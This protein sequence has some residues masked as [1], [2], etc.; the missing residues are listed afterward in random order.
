MGLTVKEILDTAL[1]MVTDNGG[2]LRAKSVFWLHEVMRDV[3]NQPRQWE[4]L[5]TVSAVLV[6]SSNQVTLPVDCGEVFNFTVDDGQGREYFF[7]PQEALLS[8]AESFDEDQLSGVAPTGYTLTATTLIF[9]PA[10]SGTCTINYEPKL[11]AV[12]YTDTDLVSGTTFFPAEFKNVLMQGVRAKCWT[13][14]HDELFTDAKS[15]YRD[16][17][18]LIKLLDN[19]KKALPKVDPHGYL[20]DRI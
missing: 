10:A 1:M 19:T 8:D 2:T 17:L 9:H 3:M 14:E 18:R 11:P 6:I 15:D 13:S 16:E 20:R 4:M 5:K 12:D 7:Q